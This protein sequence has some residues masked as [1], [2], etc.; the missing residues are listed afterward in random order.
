MFYRRGYLC[1]VSTSRRRNGNVGSGNV[2]R[3]P[4]IRFGVYGKA[5]SIAAAVETCLVLEAPSI[6]IESAQEQRKGTCKP[7]SLAR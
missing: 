7:S 2:A 3:R 5:K 1:P 4:D 6:D